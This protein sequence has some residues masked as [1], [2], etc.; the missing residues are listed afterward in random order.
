VRTTSQYETLNTKLDNLA[1]AVKNGYRN[2][3]NENKIATISKFKEILDQSQFKNEFAQNTTFLKFIDTLIQ[4]SN[5]KRNTLKQWKQTQKKLLEFK[6]FSN[7]EIDFD[8]ID[9]DFYEWF[10]NFL[11]KKGYAKNTM[12][13]LLRL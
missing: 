10:I 12:A 7:T 9:L 4:N 2:L 13:A 11:T 5:R 8:N 3:V 6:K 1:T